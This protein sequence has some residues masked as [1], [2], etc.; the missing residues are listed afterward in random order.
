MTGTVCHE[1][2]IGDYATWL[3]QKDGIN[4]SAPRCDYKMIDTDFLLPVAMKTYF[5]DTESGRQRSDDFFRTTATFLTDN[6]GLSYAQLAQFTAEKIMR[7]AAPFAENPIKENLI[8]LK[9]GE[10]VGEWRDSNNGLGGGRIPYDV[11]AALIPASLRAI[12]ALSLTGFFPEHENWG[13]TA[14]R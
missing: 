2:V 13:E 8:H 5:V 3:N 4:S 10:Q 9:E 6:N 7:L 1:E 14:A 11:N 12:A